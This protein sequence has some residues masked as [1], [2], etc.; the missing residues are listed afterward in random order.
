MIIEDS[1]NSK[2]NINPKGNITFK[3]DSNE[4]KEK[5]KTGH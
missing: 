3:V 1:I 2:D 5:E 4:I